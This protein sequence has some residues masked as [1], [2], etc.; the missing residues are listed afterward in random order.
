MKSWKNVSDY[1]FSRGMPVILADLPG[2]G[3]ADA[4]PAD[5]GLDF[6]SD[7]IRVVVDAI[8]VEK[9][10]IVS[11]SYG[12]PIAYTFAARYPERVAKLILAGTMK[13][14]PAHMRQRVADTLI[15][16]RQGRMEQFAR[17]V[18]EGLVVMDPEV[19]VRRRHLAYRLLCSQLTSISEEDMQKYVLNTLRILNHKSLDLA[20]PP[21]CPT[22]VYTGE[23]DSFTTPDYCLEIANSIGCSLFTT[24]NNADHMF[25]IQRPSVVNE[26]SYEFLEN[27]VIT[28]LDDI[29]PVLASGYMNSSLSRN[30][31]IAA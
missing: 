8:G 26:I 14:V 16:L 9:V 13:E 15:P 2:T 29:G 3:S 7:A 11:A 22:L 18:A 20:T 21:Q 5:Y 25:H 28:S 4:L 12:T 10:S 30:L 1:F 6:L 24:I 31:P 23:H 27:G 19:P 17:E